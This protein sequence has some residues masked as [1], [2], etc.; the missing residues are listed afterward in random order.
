MSDKLSTEAIKHVINEHESTGVT[1]T[2]RRARA[3]LAAI[4]K[5]VEEQ[6]ELV[7]ALEDQLAKLYTVRANEN[8]AKD[9]RVEEQK[10]QSAVMREALRYVEGELLARQYAA[11]EVGIYRRE[12]ERIESALKREAD[13]D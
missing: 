2:P 3:E 10:S 6:G 4:L 1:L 11:G 7:E 12:L 13:D 5:R 8:E 9:K